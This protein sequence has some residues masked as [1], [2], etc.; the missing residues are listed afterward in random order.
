MM[1]TKLSLECVRCVVD[2]VIEKSR[3]MGVAGIAV[4]IVDDGAHLV[5]FARMERAFIGAIELALNKAST[6][7]RFR[8]SSAQL[9]ELSRNGGPLAGIEASLPG[10]VTFGG[11]MPLMDCT[12]RCIGAIGVSGGLVEQDEVIAKAGVTA[13]NHVTSKENT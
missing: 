12:G 2:A 4:A 7:A 3:V 10:L 6:A 13:F 5:A 9:G 1:S 8:V 11:G